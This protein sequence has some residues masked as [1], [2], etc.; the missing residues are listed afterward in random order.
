MK[1]SRQD[2]VHTERCKIRHCKNRLAALFADKPRLLEVKKAYASIKGIVRHTRAS[3]A[4][5]FS[6][7]YARET[8]HTNAVCY[9]IM[10]ERGLIK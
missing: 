3:N 1:L 6:K 7:I 2:E 8:R 9:E 5:K 4:R 10:K